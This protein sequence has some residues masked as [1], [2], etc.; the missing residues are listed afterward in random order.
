MAAKSSFRLNQRDP[1]RHPALVEFFNCHDILLEDFST[2]YHRMWSLHPT[3]CENVSMKNLTIR[4]TG[5]ND[6]GIDVDSCKHVRIE[7]CNFSIGD[8]CISLKSGRG[9]EGY[10]LHKPG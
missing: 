5:G 2:S 6:D 4:S 7:S 8:D 9:S 1:L 10:H 3:Y